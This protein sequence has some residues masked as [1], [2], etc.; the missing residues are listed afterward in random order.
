M[1]FGNK[2]IHFAGVGS[3]MSFYHNG[4]GQAVKSYADWAIKRYALYSWL[5]LGKKLSNFEYD[6]EINKKYELLKPYT[7]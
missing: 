2:L 7:T 6:D 5:V 1:D 4:L 3:G